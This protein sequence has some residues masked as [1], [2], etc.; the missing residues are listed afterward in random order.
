MSGNIVLSQEKKNDYDEIPYESNPYAQSHPEHL[1]TLGFLFGMDPVSMDKA[2]ILELGCSSGGNIIPMAYYSPG[3]KIIGI[4][5]SKVQIELANS[6]VKDLGLKNIE[7]KCCSIADL[8][9]SLGKFDYIIVH[10]IFSWVPIEI[11]KKI[12]EVCGK[13]LTEQGIAY[14]SYNR[15]PGWNMV[16]SIRDMMLYHGSFFTNIHEKINQSKV[17]LNFVSSSL[18]GQQSPFA[19]FLKQ[20]MKLLEKQPDS[21]LRH[22]HL[23]EI[24]QPYYF[25][26]F[27]TEANGYGLQYLADSKVSSMFLGN[28]PPKVI[29]QLSVINDIV[30]LEQYMD[31]IYNRRFRTTL[32]C[33]NNVSLNRSLTADDINKFYLIFKIIPEKP[34][35]TI[36]LN[37]KKEDLKFYYNNTEMSVSTTSPTMKAILY[38]FAE[39]VINPLKV[40]SIIE[41][42]SKKIKN[43]AEQIK[44]DLLTQGM[45]FFL[46]GLIDIS[47][48]S[49]VHIKQIPSKPKVSQLTK[50]QVEKTPNLWVTNNKHER[51]SINFFDKY[52][53]RYMDGSISK[54]QIILKVIENHVNNGEVTLSKDNKKIED[55]IEIKKEL[56][57]FM[58]QTLERLL[59]NCLFVL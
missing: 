14:I 17:F 18:D 40:E 4:D 13:L 19:L 43:S 28:M 22:D 48:V 47:L 15:L 7:F 12:F 30:R 37:N 5:S 6:C 1:R 36:D 33:R 55:K 50:Y 58:E 52:A 41:L 42:A 57:L 26:E 53:L 56:E 20:E 16:K 51:I 59:Q 29:E 39:N 31:F 27:M 23:E 21:Y 9:G 45:Q 38:T 10:G 11:R 54:D 49:N 25:Y 3:S 8:D 46:K 35:S 32:L 34:L 2:R 24:N 44:V